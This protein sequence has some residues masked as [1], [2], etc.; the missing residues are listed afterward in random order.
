[1][2]TKQDYIDE[3]LTLM[4]NPNTRW[5]KIVSAML[6][7][8]MNDVPEDKPPIAGESFIE[9]DNGYEA[10]INNLKDYKAKLLG[11]DI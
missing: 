1:M 7:E 11:K 8:I 10:A 2:K 6:D 4:Q 9:W 5:N 3:A